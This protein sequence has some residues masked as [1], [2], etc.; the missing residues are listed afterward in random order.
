[1]RLSDWSRVVSVRLVHHL[2]AWE[3]DYYAADIVITSDL[4]NAQLRIHVT[5]EDLDQ[6]AEALDRIESDEH[7]PTEGE[8]LTVDWP[9][10]GRQGYLRFIAEDPYVVEVHD[11]PQTQVSVRVP[12]DM[13]EDW[14][15]EAR[16]RLD[17]VSRLLGRD[18]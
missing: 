18:G 16:Q 15:K 10:A 13:D 11:A 17:A 14:I 8:A 2:P 5:L 12:L 3:P 1:M 4:V 7:Q 9:A 6:W